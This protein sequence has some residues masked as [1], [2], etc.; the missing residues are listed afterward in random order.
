MFQC[1]ENNS[2]QMNDFFKQENFRKDILLQLF[3]LIEK[4]ELSL[5]K[6]AS[7]EKKYERMYRGM[8]LVTKVSGQTVTLARDSGES[9]GVLAL[10]KEICQRLRVGDRFDIMLG[11]REQQWRPLFVGAIISQVPQELL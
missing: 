5:R 8:V 3:S 11:L 2:L 9:L 1:S 4:E 10:N 7:A 6:P